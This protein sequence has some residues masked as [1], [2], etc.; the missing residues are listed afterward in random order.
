[1]KNQVARPA[2]IFALVL[3]LCVVSSAQGADTKKHKALRATGK[4]TVFLV[5][6]TA[7]ATFEA[8]KF[9]GK[10]VVGPAVKEVI[11]PL[12]KAAP[13]VTKKLVK[14]TANGINKAA[15]AISHRG[16][17]EDNADPPGPKTSDH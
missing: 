8:A 9:T 1:M 7:K 12:A 5:K 16:N 3:L 10:Y 14:I 13:S 15:D 6:T 11:V 17:D 2:G 4:I